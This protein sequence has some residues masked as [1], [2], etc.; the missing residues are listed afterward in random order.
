MNKPL[1]LLQPQ[2]D[3]SPCS[4]LCC[5]LCKPL[6]PFVS[7]IWACFPPLKS[8]SCKALVLIW[9]SV[10][11]L[12]ILYYIAICCYHLT[13]FPLPPSLHFADSAVCGPGGAFIAAGGGPVPERAAETQWPSGLCRHHH[14]QEAASAPEPDGTTAG[15]EL[16]VRTPFKSLSPHT[17]LMYFWGLVLWLLFFYLLYSTQEVFFSYCLVFIQSDNLN[18]Q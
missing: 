7:L 11:L 14:Q 16:Q 2:R 17:C 4:M 15:G 5:V 3:Q 13:I 8:I 18:I 10:T 1:K 12:W 9:C 6:T